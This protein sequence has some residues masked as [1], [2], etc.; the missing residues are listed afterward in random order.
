MDRRPEGSVAILGLGLMGGSLGLALT[1]AGL[2]V[3]GWDANPEAINEAFKSGAINQ[4]AESM[5]EAVR[6]ASV[7]FIATPVASIPEVIRGC[8]SF[9]APGSIFTDL[10][11]IKEQVIDAVFAV[12][13]A[14]HYFVAG[15]PMTGSE[16]Q[17][18]AAADPFLFQNAA[19]IVIDDPR[20]P[21]AALAQVVELVKL[22]GAHVLQLTAAAHD[23]TVAMVSHLPH[24]IAATLAKAAGMAEEA[25]PRYPG[26]GSRRLSGYHPG[27]HRQSP[28]LGGHY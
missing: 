1:R 19:Y 27:G 15:H 24:L 8:L 14:S 9:T 3:S 2:K 12:L 13:P 21:A 5:G 23:R 4:A 26:P 18:M 11:S 7:I 17:G 22:T 10:G 16:Q 28:A 25:Q 20:T 6:E